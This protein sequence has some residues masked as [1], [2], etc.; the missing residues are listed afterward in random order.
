MLDP[1]SRY[2]ATRHDTPRTVDA[3]AF[4]HYSDPQHMQTW[5]EL[6]RRL[7]QSSRPSRAA[8]FVSETFSDAY[9]ETDNAYLFGLYIE[10]YLASSLRLH[11]A[12]NHTF[13]H[14]KSS[15][16]ICC[17]NWILAKF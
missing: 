3:R 15:P 7:R 9:D 2:E 1:S 8:A 4:R 6:N 10:S 16:S 14:C 5:P 17:R 12:S 11:V 13:P